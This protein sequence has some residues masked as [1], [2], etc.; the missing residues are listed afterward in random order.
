MRA[1][2]YSVWVGGLSSEVQE[3]DL[4]RVF[5]RCGRVM[6]CKI[7]PG[8]ITKIN[9]FGEAELLGWAF[10]DFKDE[11]GAKRALRELNGA[12]IQGNCIDVR[13]RTADKKP[14]YTYNR[15]RGGS[16]PR[17]R[18]DVCLFYSRGRCKYGSRVSST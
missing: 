4:R 8:T 9:S 6:G 10:V 11:E 5:E 13:P 1:A 18:S 2:N 12:E 14:T 3:R 15:D 7:R 16:Q 17:S